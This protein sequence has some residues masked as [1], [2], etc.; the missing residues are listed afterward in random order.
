MFGFQR[1]GDAIWAAADQR[2]RGFLLGAT[3]GRTTL[4]GEGLQHQDGSS[5][6]V[7]ATIPN[8]R[9]WDPAFA[10]EM[11]LIVDHGMRRMLLQQC[12]EFFYITLMNEN[13]AQPDLPPG[14]AEG[15]LRGG[16]LFERVA[17]EGDAVGEV[18]LLGSGAILTEVRRAARLL[19]A[20]GIASTVF[21][22][23]SWSELARQGQDWERLRDLASDAGAP[24]S[25]A[26]PYVAQLLQ[27]GQGPVVAATDYV[28][29]VPEGI[30]AY[31]PTGREFVTLGTDGFGRSDTRSAL[32]EFFGVD[33][34]HIARAA[35]GACR[36]C[37]GSAP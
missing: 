17:A 37:A 29:A 9:A 11:A 3:S 18:T 33:A 19:A 6:L 28:R 36:R 26:L 31:V 27:Q 34:A 5:Q 14:A 16:Y 13:Y 32:R 10:G 4:G 15:V 25:Q 8:C 30:R 23:T 12:D 1:V 20:E 22:I 21:S 2:A 24:A 7:A 35:R